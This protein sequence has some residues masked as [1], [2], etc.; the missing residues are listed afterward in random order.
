[1]KC[2]IHIA[3]LLAC[4]LL[5]TVPAFGHGNIYLT[6]HDLDYHCA[7]Q[8]PPTACN[9]F[10]IAVLFAVAGAPDKTK[11]VLFLDQGDQVAIAATQAG[12]STGGIT[13]NPTSTT[14]TGSYY[15]YTAPLALTAEGGA[16]NYSAIV[17]AS[18]Y[19]CGGCDNDVNGENAINARSGDIANFFAAGGGL[20]YLSAG[21]NLDCND[22]CFDTGSWTRYYNSVPSA[23]AV[24]G[25]ATS[26]DGVDPQA[27]G[28]LT[29]APTGPCYQLTD[30]GI[31]L[32]LNNNDANCCYTHNSFSLIGGNQLTKA[33]TDPL[34]SDS[35]DNPVTLYA[36]DA[37][38]GSQAAVL[39]FTPGNNV[40]R[41]GLFNC[42]AAAPPCPNPNANSMKFTFTTVKK[43]FTVVLSATEVSPSGTC[44]IPPSGNANDDTTN[45]GCRLANFFADHKPIGN[46][47]IH[48]YLFSPGTILNVPY[49]DAYSNGNCVFYRIQNPPNNTNSQ[50]YGGTI[51]FYIAWNSPITPPAGY[52][53]NPQMYDDPSNDLDA[54]DYPS[55]PGFPYAPEDHQFVFN[56]TTYFNPNGQAGLGDPGIGG[57][58]RTAN[59]WVVAFPLTSPDNAQLVAP[60]AKPD[61]AIYLS[62]LPMLVAFTLENKTSDVSDP[63]A[64]T[65]PNYVNAA[66]L[67][68]NG[69]R[70]SVQTFPGAPNTFTYASRSRFPFTDDPLY[71][72]VLDPSIYTLN[73]VYQLQVQSNL[74][75]APLTKNFKV[76]NWQMVLSGTCK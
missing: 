52:A 28:C 47:T 32:G 2:H 68:S 66:V 22:G 48:P 20:V 43:T 30:A 15:P 40:S 74:F 34:V 41:T 45:F 17:F 26:L 46:Y 67:D 61:T 23:Y 50:F 16:P 60:F 54:A 73:K 63:S 3:I 65:R 13:V 7:F 11:P 42:G 27:N 76:C 51:N 38:P 36:F 37:P 24:T 53:N 19:T 25:I 71:Y 31:A 58:G 21:E 69:V 33:E 59:D 49:C 5:M 18:D 75:D 9:A 10:K 56:I 72:I 12:L 14:F 39:T 35:G 55:T 4:C 1:M 44:T 62:S 70:Q 8:S 29:S 6:G 57:S 64:V